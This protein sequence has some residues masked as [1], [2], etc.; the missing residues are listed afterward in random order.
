MLMASF[1]MSTDRKVTKFEGCRWRDSLIGIGVPSG[2][3]KLPNQVTLCA[4]TYQDTT[5]SDWDCM[6][7]HRDRELLNRC[8]G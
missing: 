1:R 5:V 2:V 3:P 6:A 7:A 8:T 4:R